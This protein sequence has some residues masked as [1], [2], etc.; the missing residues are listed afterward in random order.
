MKLAIIGLGSMGKRR[1]RLLMELSKDIVLFGVDSNSE[2]TDEVE[3]LFGISTYSNLQTLIGQQDIDA[4]FVCTSPVTHE[5]IILEALESKLHVF[6]EINLLNNY[7]DRA[8]ELAASNNVHIYIS[9]TFLHRKEIQYMEDT[10]KNYPKV[11]YRYHVGQYLPDWHPWESYKDFF[12]SDKR[13]NGCREILAIELPWIT[14][15][16]GKIDSVFSTGAKIS[17]LDIDFPDTYNILIKHQDGIM[18]SLTVDIVSRVAVRNLDVIG[19][20]VQIKWDGTPTGLSVWNENQK[21]MVNQSVYKQ[22]TDDTNYS[23]TIIEDAYKEE[24][25]EFLKLLKGEITETL[26]CLK[27]DY[28]VINIINKIEEE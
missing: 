1:I 28:D 6:T 20:Q 23:K 14:K 22:F 2:R 15:V 12:V 24:I 13:T 8:V 26:Y 11:A 18:G 9:S 25:I 10:V 3:N 16:F 27:D 21:K 19:E 4:V 5:S 7:Y 17:T